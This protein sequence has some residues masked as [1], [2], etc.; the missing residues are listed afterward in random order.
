MNL[1]ILKIPKKN[2]KESF[3]QENDILIDKDLL[4]NCLP[5]RNIS[6][7]IDEILQQMQ[8]LFFAK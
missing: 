8:M 3:F 2:S 5:K 1:F 7:G 6:N 4:I